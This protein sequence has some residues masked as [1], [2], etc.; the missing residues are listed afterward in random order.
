V[1][2]G[3]GDIA[4]KLNFSFIFICKTVNYNAYRKSYMSLRL[5]NSVMLESTRTVLTGNANL[6]LDSTVSVPAT[7]IVK[8]IHALVVVADLNPINSQATEWLFK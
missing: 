7:K 3:K 5:S 2:E 8:F 1:A 6:L 4:Q